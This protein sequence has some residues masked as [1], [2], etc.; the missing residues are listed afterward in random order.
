MRGALTDTEDING[1]PNELSQIDDSDLTGM[2]SALT[3]RLFAIP[4]YADLFAEAYPTVDPSDFG[5]QHAANAIAAFEASAFAF[6]DSPFDQYLAGDSSAL[7]AAQKRGA[8]LFFGKAGC[9]RCHNGPLLTDQ[10]HYNL[11][12]PQLGPG[13]A[14]D[15]PFDFGRERE[16]DNPDD[17]FAFRT[18]PLRNVE[19]TGPWM[20]NGAYTTLRGAIEHHLNPISALLNYDKSQLVGEDLQDT[21][22][23]DD[24]T[25]QLIIDATDKKIVRRIRLKSDELDDLEEFLK[26][27]TMSED[28]VA[29]L[30]N[31]VP[32]TVPSGLPVDGVE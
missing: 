2:W 8:L 16:T 17:L 28:A 5:F 32:E 14:P 31:S 1:G 18:P 10:E 12:V 27:L 11:A 7:T 9:A 26:S 6:L 23:D 30:F 21:V 25:L 3:E 20:H 24:D 4:A 15:Q 22:R 19:I 13:K 29:T